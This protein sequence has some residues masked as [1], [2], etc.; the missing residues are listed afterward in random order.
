M[1]HDVKFSVP[2]RELGKADIVFEIKK[3]KEK[4]GTLKVSKGSVVWFP[5]DTTYGHKVGWNKFDGL[6]QGQTKKEKR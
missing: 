3:G 5:R 6:M 1:N 2:K 4:F